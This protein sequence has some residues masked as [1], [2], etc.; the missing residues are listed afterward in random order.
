[1]VGGN[2]GRA[3]PCRGRASSV[4]GYTC[5]GLFLRCPAGTLP[6]AWAGTFP[7]LGIV[8]A[9]HNAFT[10]TA[11]AALRSNCR[12]ACN[13]S[14][15]PA[16]SGLHHGLAPPPS[17]PELTFIGNLRSACEALPHGVAPAPT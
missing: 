1:M 5:C 13:P 11:V 4:H 12:S 10:G 3:C 14:C 9:S 16:S 6:E 2:S 8:N 7:Q 15:V 17:V